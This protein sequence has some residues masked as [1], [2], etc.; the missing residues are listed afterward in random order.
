VSDDLPIL[1][2][3]EARVLGS[4]AEKKELTPDVY[5]MTVNGLQSAA[6]Q[7]TSREPVM[8]LEQVEVHRALKML[9]DKGLVRQVFASRVERY[10]HLLA[11]K[12]SL[13]Q[14]QIALVGLMLL[15][16]PQT[17][18]E[19]YARA[20]RLA[21]FKSIDEVRGDLDL[22]IGRRPPLVQLIERGPGQREERYA[23][24]LSG[25]VQ[26]TGTAEPVSGATLAHRPDIEER[27]E[28]LERQV[29]E[30]TE[31]LRS[32]TGD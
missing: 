32:L 3:A 26:A 19:L 30:L 31:K 25:Q 7:K 9:T 2:P 12:F 17:V 22:L 8:A 4:L 21:R 11:Q 10:E 20:E 18:H 16:G 29:A 5:P 13:T 1:S 27:I 23:H 28:A 15:R 24:L 6:N 14:S